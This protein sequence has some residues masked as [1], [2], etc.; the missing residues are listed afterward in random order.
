MGSQYRGPSPLAPEYPGEA[1]PALTADWIFNKVVNRTRSTPRLAFCLG[2]PG[3]SV[4]GGF[5]CKEMLGLASVF[6]MEII[7]LVAA[8]WVASSRGEHARLTAR[9]RT[10]GSSGSTSTQTRCCKRSVGRAL[11]VRGR[12][13]MDLDAG[14][15]GDW[16]LPGIRSLAASFP[17]FCR[18][19]AVN[20]RTRSSVQLPFPGPEMCG[21]CVPASSLG[22]PHTSAGRDRENVLVHARLAGH[23]S[24]S[25]KMLD[26][27]A[28]DRRKICV[29]PGTGAP[30]GAI[31]LARVCPAVGFDCRAGFCVEHSG[32]FGLGTRDE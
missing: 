31:G 30:I 22:L 19:K 13:I 16:R 18:E 11:P 26:C 7:N 14:G 6:G 15:W 25:R 29:L 32:F 23:F 27:V 21:L 1:S 12:Y 9:P 10:S 28:C 24:R 4:V 2:S 5:H 3:T 17:P 8:P 20:Q